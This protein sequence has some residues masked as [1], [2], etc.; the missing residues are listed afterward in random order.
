MDNY[1]SLPISEDIPANIENR[2]RAK[3]QVADKILLKIL[4]HY[5]YGDFNIEE[6]RRLENMTRKD[7]FIGRLLVL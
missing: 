2:S 4:N 5:Q 6:D 7:L 3:K 1:D